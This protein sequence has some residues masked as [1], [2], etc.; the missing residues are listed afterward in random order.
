MHRSAFLVLGLIGPLF[1]QATTEKWDI[2]SGGCG[3]F[4]YVEHIPDAKLKNTFSDRRKT[5]P[6]VLLD[7]YPWEEG[8]DCCEGKTST[9][10]A[11]TDKKGRF[12][13]DALTPGKYWIVARWNLKDYRKR[14][15]FM[16]VKTADVRC[17]EQ[18]FSI[19]NDGKF[20]EWVTITVD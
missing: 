16:S 9:A 2:M 7:L 13:F 8:K 12:K 17:A 14:V 11:V 4:E 18:G 20:E 19:D 6:D 5:L 1:Q 3:V 15:E 10:Q